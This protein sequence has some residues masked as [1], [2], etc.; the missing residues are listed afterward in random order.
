MDLANG[1]IVIAGKDM[2]ILVAY[3]IFGLLAYLFISE[4]QKKQV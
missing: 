4:R 2:V 1:G 3:C